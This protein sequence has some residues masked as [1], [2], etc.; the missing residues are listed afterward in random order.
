MD[1]R[2]KNSDV[3]YSMTLKEYRMPGS[4]NDAKAADKTG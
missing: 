2:E 1:T 4:E 3:A